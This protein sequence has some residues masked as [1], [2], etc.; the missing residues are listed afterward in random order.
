MFGKLVNEK[1]N[2]LST[3]LII[4]F[5]VEFGYLFYFSAQR[6]ITKYSHT[7]FNKFPLRYF[8]LLAFGLSICQLVK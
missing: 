8:N 3:H 4:K 1:I 7:E 5:Q 2:I 6:K